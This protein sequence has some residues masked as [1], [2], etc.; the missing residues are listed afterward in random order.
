MLEIGLIP[1]DTGQPCGKTTG[2][3]MSHYIRDDGNFAKHCADLLGNG[4]VLPFFELWD[5]AKAGK[6]KAKNKTKFV[7]DCCGAAAW[8]KPEL[9][10]V[11]AECDEVMLADC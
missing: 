5:E 11:C 4:F 7:C 6:A 10:I 3:K 8:G 9:R 1:S 2:Q